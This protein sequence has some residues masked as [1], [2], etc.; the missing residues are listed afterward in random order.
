MNSEVRSKN[1]NID[2][3]YVHLSEVE[4]EYGLVRCLVSNFPPP[5]C[6]VTS[7]FAYT[8]AFAE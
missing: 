2:F 3:S 7:L 5:N 6:I 1:N 4:R 8:P